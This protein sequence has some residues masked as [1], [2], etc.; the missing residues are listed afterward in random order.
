M[1]QRIH[2]L[3]WRPTEHESIRV[4]KMP[5]APHLD[6]FRRC[7]RRGSPSERQE[8]KV[9]HSIS[10]FDEFFLLRTH[11]LKIRDVIAKLG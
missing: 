10:D 11:F 3:G 5:G 1:P 7:Y 9:S 8:A 4:D 6:L 2:H